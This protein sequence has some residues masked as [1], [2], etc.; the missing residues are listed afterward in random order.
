MGKKKKKYEEGEYRCQAPGCNKIITPEKA[1]LSFKV[2]RS[3]VYCSKNCSRRAYKKRKSIRD[4][5]GYPITKSK[6]AH[7]KVQGIRIDLRARYGIA[8]KGIKDAI[9]HR[10]GFRCIWCRAMLIQ[11]P[12]ITLDHV[13]P[14]SVFVKNYGAE[15]Y[16][17]PTN[18]VVSC[19]DCNI[20]RG[21]KSVEEFAAYVSSVR[22]EAEESILSRIEALRNKELLWQ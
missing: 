14:V 10:D 2:K 4:G 20:I 15:L 6:I 5:G 16:Y 21:D 19:Q 3:P 13:I 18:I 17:D 1:E 8:I 9:W 22:G 11:P 7:S 12:D